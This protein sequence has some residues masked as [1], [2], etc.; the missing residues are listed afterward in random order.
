MSSFWLA[1]RNSRLRGSGQTDRC[2]RLQRGLSNR[3]LSA[4]D[5]FSFG[6]FRLLFAYDRHFLRTELRGEK[7]NAN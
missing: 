7:Q 2:S 4:R 5:R 6:I 1:H 3:D